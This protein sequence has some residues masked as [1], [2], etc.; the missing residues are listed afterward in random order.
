MEHL[1]STC[2][3]KYIARYF[4][5]GEEESL[6]DTRLEGVCVDLARLINA[7]WANVASCEEYMT[8][9]HNSGMGQ[10]QR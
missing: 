5:D 3:C 6:E 2:T 8:P 4:G 1:S 7:T 9:K 10:H